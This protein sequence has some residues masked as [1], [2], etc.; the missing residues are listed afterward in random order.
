MY[1][2]IYFRREGITGE[3]NPKSLPAGNSDLMDVTMLKELQVC[4]VQ[5]IKPVEDTWFS[6]VFLPPE[7]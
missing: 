6:A 2:R 7:I 1:T 4:S 3:A 5:F